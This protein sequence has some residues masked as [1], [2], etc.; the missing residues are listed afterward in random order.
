MAPLKSLL[1]SLFAVTAA[2]G[3]VYFSVLTTPS[4]RE[5]STLNPSHTISDTSRWT[6]RAA[7]SLFQQASREVHHLHA[8][9]GSFHRR[10][11]TWERAIER[12]SRMNCYFSMTVDEMD[13]AQEW[14]PNPTFGYP[15]SSQSEYTNAGDLKKYGW[16]F[17][18]IPA[19]FAES[20]LPPYYSIFKDLS[21]PADLKAWV[22][23]YS[24]HEKEVTV[25]ID[26]ATE[27]FPVSNLD[28]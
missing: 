21:I 2:I 5:R 11:V 27:T 12:G 8:A 22:G 17:E 6:T 14:P 10:E 26:G 15:R 4:V 19:D 1:F 25:T 28:L 9:H 24:E 16:G 13:Q 7:S 3:L 23:V 18:E 20:Y